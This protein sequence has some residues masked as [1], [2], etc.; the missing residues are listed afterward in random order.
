MRRQQL[1]S[2]VVP[3]S[4]IVEHAG[5]DLAIRMGASGAENRDKSST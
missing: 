3:I 5:V 4:S 2:F 1:G